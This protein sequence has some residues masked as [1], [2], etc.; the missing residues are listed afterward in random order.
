[1][2]KIITYILS[3]I[4][5]L[6]ILN[7]P[8]QL[9]NMIYYGCYGLMA[10]Y[11]FVTYFKSSKLN[12]IMCLFVFVGFLSIAMNLIRNPDILYFKPLSRLMSFMI[13]MLAI[14]PLFVYSEHKYHIIYHNLLSWGFV[15]ISLISFVLFCLNLSLAYKKGTF[16]GFTTHSMLLGPI[17]ALSTLLLIHR[18][19][20]SD[21]IKIKIL[22]I[23]GIIIAILT[24]L[25][26]G[27]RGALGAMLFAII[28]LLYKQYS[29]KTFSILIFVMLSVIITTKPLWFSYTEAVQ[30]KI[31]YASEVGHSSRDA[32]WE[33][34]IK[35][36]ID[37]PILGQG[38]CAMN[39]SI[40]THTSYSDETRGIESGSSWL[41]LLSSMGG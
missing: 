10:T 27:S 11:F 20:L 32:L 39:R 22:Y 1:M 8:L 35:E 26:A 15:M 13:M 31:E 41:F 4:N 5:I 9:P 33:D 2:G 23:I 25:L 30:K 24:C 7:I 6:K 40:A 36:F 3:I 37:S 19:Y 29:K 17:C 18:F 16:I 34:R 14:G 28:F 38:F 21:N 12:T